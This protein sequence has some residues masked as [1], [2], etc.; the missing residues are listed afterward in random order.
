MSGLKSSISIIYKIDTVKLNKFKSI[1]K[2]LGFNYSESTGEKRYLDVVKNYTK[3][4]KYT[5]ENEKIDDNVKLNSIFL[6]SYFKKSADKYENN[7][8]VFS[9]N[10]EDIDIST[11]LLNRKGKLDIKSATSKWVSNFRDNYEE[12]KAFFTDNFKSISD[13]LLDIKDTSLH[14]RYINDFD[15]AKVASL[16][17]VT[18]KDN[19]DNLKGVTTNYYTLFVNAKDSIAL[20]YCN[21]KATNSIE[22]LNIFL[23]S[24]AYKDYYQ[25]KNVI[26]IEKAD[27]IDLEKVTKDDYQKLLKFSTQISRNDTIYFFKN[28]TEVLDYETYHDKLKIDQSHDEFINGL[29]NL[30]NTIK[31]IHEFED[32]K[33]KDKWEKIGYFVAFIGLSATIV[34]AWAAVLAIPN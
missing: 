15:E 12:L 17:G 11:E 2:N 20:E 29:N 6:G 8:I 28:P 22:N 5:L 23:I 1:F 27:N 33:F 26:T 32:W 18:K 7:Y 9:F 30:L 24:L 25:N 3:V 16:T 4:Y 13:Q 21:E 34:G 19:I 31:L 10:I 14:I